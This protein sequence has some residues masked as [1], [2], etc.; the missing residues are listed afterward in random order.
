MGPRRFA[1]RIAAVA[2]GVTLVG[3]LASG[4]GVA[5]KET[6]TTTQTTT[7]PASSTA[8]A[9]NPQ[10]PSFTPTINPGPAP[11]TCTRVVNGVCYR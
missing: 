11:A 9:G 4:C 10:G 6:P 8:K 5:G 7:V 2:G 3:A 1:S